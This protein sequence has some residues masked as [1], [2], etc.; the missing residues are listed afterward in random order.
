MKSP[1]YLES[2]D[3]LPNIVLIK[4][5]TN[6]TK[7]WNWE[8]KA[9]FIDDYKTLINSY[10]ALSTKP[11]IILLTPLRCFITRQLCPTAC[12]PRLLAQAAWL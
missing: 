10:R 7:P 1:Q 2:L 6:D 3:F 11:R 5:G 12:I 8:H 9:D 4:L